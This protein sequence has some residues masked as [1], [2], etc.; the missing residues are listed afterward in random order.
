MVPR[1]D[2]EYVQ[3][4]GGGELQNGRRLLL[5]GFV[6][7]LLQQ[8][9]KQSTWK[10]WLEVVSDRGLDYRR[11]RYRILRSSRFPRCWARAKDVIY[12]ERYWQCCNAGRDIASH[13]GNLSPTQ[14]G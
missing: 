3:A 11:Q 12:H 2:T 10:L 13:P 1:R 5:S 9:R 6:V 8:V 14:L 7:G 4:F